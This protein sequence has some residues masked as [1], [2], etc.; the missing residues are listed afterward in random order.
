M[1]KVNAY[2][3]T[4]AMNLK[5]EYDKS[6]FNQVVTKVKD[7]FKTVEA[8]PVK[9]DNEKIAKDLKD[10]VEKART[11]AG[12]ATLQLL[13]A[14][15]TLTDE[16]KKAAYEAYDKQTEALFKIKKLKDEIAAQEMFGNEDSE[17]LNELKK[18]LEDIKKEAEKLGLKEDSNGDYKRQNLKDKNENEDQ[19][20]ADETEQK[21]TFGSGFKESAKDWASEHT[22]AAYGK[23]A[24]AKMANDIEKFKDKALE[25]FKKFV[26]DALEEL[27]EM[28]SWDITGSTTYNKNASE[29]Y[30][31]YG[32]QGADAYAM[33][34]ALSATGIDDIETY[35]TDPLVQGNEA[36]LDNFNE[37]YELAKAQY[38]DDLKIA[39][40]YQKFEKEFD[41]FKQELQKSLIDFF[42]ENKD[43]IMDIMKFLMQAMED[44][45]KSFG[46]IVAFFG[47]DTV[48]DRSEEQRQSDMNEL[49]G[50]T[51]NSTI[52]YDNRSNNV[53]VSNTYNGVGKVDQ[54]SLQN[55]GQMTYQQII[56]YLGRD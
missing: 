37:Q 40:E 27:K 11:E 20:T 53:N 7:D 28:A 33:S 44:V 23:Q 19:E 2:V 36:L 4:F 54:T 32:L 18:E 35:L 26:D 29:M 47:G 8:F 34:K 25:T 39:K 16:Q 6:S 22:P 14:S 49:L 38:Q 31:S 9:F 12:D 42:M 50:V 3:K 30:M 45:V 10:A 56:E 5:A 48:K 24:F 1:D 41:L 52:S 51:N 21:S 43:T 15:T 17:I 55:V 46:E 13:N